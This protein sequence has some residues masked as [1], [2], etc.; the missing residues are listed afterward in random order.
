MNNKNIVIRNFSSEDWYDVCRV[1]E[2]AT[3]QEHANAGIDPKAIRPLSDEED[4]NKF[5]EQN[6]ARVA[7]IDSQIVGF[8]AWREGGYLSWLYISPEHQRCGIG[9]RLLEEA[10]TH[11]GKQAWTLTKGGNDPAITLYQKYGM[12]IVISYSS[13]TWGYPQTEL[14]LALPT[15][16]KYDPN[17]PNFGA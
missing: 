7:C 9:S 1:Y 16:R 11:L 17:V 15:S 4:L 13:E 10:M 14:R 6:S 12:E 8:V 2:L 5:L 3:V